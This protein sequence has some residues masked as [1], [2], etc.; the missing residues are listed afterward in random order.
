MQSIS[1]P[2]LAA[3]GEGLS[4]RH[5][6]EAWQPWMLGFWLIFL[7]CGGLFFGSPVIGAQTI[8]SPL[9]LTIA[10]PVAFAAYAGAGFPPDTSSSLLEFAM[11]AALEVLLG[12]GTGM[13]VR[14]VLAAAQGAGFLAGLA[15]GIGFA[16]VL[17]P[18]EGGEN[19]PTAQIT[20]TLSMVMFVAL[21]GL[22]ALIIW[23]GR[24]V[25][26]IPPG[27]EFDAQQISWTV[28]AAALHSI[29]L[30]VKLAYPVLA[31]VLIG[32]VGLAIVG[33]TAPQLNISSV[34]F[35]VT[36]VAGAAVAAAV[37]PQISE[38]VA[39]EAIAAITRGH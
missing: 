35:S 28:V 17:D 1:H 4:A 24:S 3:L 36:I 12:I 23:L 26:A 11:R 15:M 6:V 34:G 25:V 9:R 33:R 20:S 21:G 39:R 2:P 19:S 22:Q 31:A 16:Q 7:R 18:N 13:S 5:P 27:G 14:L 10:L 8:P 38:I 30:A 29:S 37:T 32:Q